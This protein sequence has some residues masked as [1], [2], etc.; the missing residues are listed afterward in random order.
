M[1]FTIDGV[2]AYENIQRLGKPIV[3]SVEVEHQ[4]FADGRL[5]SAYNVSHWRR[6]HTR[7]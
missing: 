3:V 1:V 2:P 4:I 5:Y 6:R 7:F